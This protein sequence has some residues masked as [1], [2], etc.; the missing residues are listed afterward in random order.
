MLLLCFARPILVGIR[1]AVHAS[2]G[3]GIVGADI[4][5]PGAG[6]FLARGSGPRIDRHVEEARKTSAVYATCLADIS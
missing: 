2:V 5:A 3:T 6:A 1:V 4:N